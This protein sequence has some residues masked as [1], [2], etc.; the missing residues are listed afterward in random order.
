LAYSPGGKI[1]ASA[2]RDRTIAFWDPATGRRLS[3]LRGHSDD[4][5]FVAFSPDGKILASAGE[6]K[7]VRLWDVAVGQPLKS[8]AGFERPLSLVLFT[9]DGA[10]LAVS[11]VHWSTGE[12]ET[13]LWAHVPV[14]SRKGN[15]RA[16]R[17]PF[18]PTAPRW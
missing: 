18:P 3:T 2:S 10:T 16:E 15:V 12:S 9:P 17:W 8:I 4:V 5:N 7:V 6:E 11:E 1:L 13:T 14:S